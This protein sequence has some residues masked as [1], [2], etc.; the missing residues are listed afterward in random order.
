[1]GLRSLVWLENQMVLL[2]QNQTCSLVW[3]V[4]SLVSLLALLSCALMLYP[5]VL[6]GGDSM[7]HVLVL[8][9]FREHL[10]QADLNIWHPQLECGAPGWIYYQPL[11]HF[12]T[13]LISIF[14]PFEMVSVYKIIVA[15][16]ISLLPWILFFSLRWMGTSV[17][18]ALIG[19]ILYLGLNT[20]VPFGIQPATFYKKGLFTMI[21]GVSFA[22]P[23]FAALFRLFNPIAGKTSSVFTAGTLLGFTFVA[24]PVLGLMC[25]FFGLISFCIYLFNALPEEKIVKSPVWPAWFSAFS[26]IS[27]VILVLMQKFFGNWKWGWLGGGMTFLAILAL[28]WLKTPS[29]RLWWQSG[30]KLISVYVF[31]NI[32]MLP[33]SAML[34][35]NSDN[36]GG[37]PMK[38]KTFLWGFPI[39]RFLFWF[40]QGN[41]LDF[42][43]VP[44]LAPIT[45]AF[46][47]FMILFYGQRHQP[48]WQMAFCFSILTAIF[49]MGFASF[50]GFVYIN[51]A[52]FGIPHF[53]YLSGLQFACLLG[54]T[55]FLGQVLTRVR[56]LLAGFILFF[57]VFLPFV[58]GARLRL[59]PEEVL[60]HGYYMK[61]HPED[62]QKAPYFDSLRQYFTQQPVRGRVHNLFASDRVLAYFPSIYTKHPVARSWGVGGQ[63]SLS[64]FYLDCP[65]YLW[66]RPEVLE[67]FAMEYILAGFKPEWVG[68]GFKA[69]RF[70][71]THWKPVD[72]GKG[73]IT[74]EKLQES[75]IALYQY[76]GEVNLFSV[77]DIGA[78]FI[79]KS[80]AARPLLWRWM[81]SEW[82]KQKAYVLLVREPEQIPENLRTLPQIQA[83]YKHW[84]EIFSTDYLFKQAPKN[85]NWNFDWP[86][87]LEKTVS[88][89]VT[90]TEVG[91]NIFRAEVQLTQPS[92]VLF[93]MSHHP[94]WKAQFKDATTPIYQASPSFMAVYL[95]AGEGE[96]V[97]R[98][99]YPFWAKISW[100]L[101]FIFM[102]GCFIR[103]LLFLFRRR[104]TVA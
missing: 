104:P 57:L 89:K 78:V 7:T 28:L 45:W 19:A 37:F 93:K 30:K 35:L 88:G 96:L 101:F 103:W 46:L 34:F 31:A 43:T 59:D 27:C 84:E 97:F 6:Y 14:L 24:H 26:G 48:L 29:F 50:G 90:A 58:G 62:H 71:G 49:T 102:F 85:A 10:K 42:N 70:F 65:T 75:D 47:G 38:P 54:A 74:A 33:F 16:M 11:G 32:V 22:F 81:E 98:Y 17:I 66:F 18:S 15:F 1:M 40:L 44:P 100:G 82:L 2:R 39:E 3:W 41:V 91:T 64:T 79:G 9:M 63:D 12:I 23:T 60:V 5:G 8:D 25:S 86:S 53:R 56:P 36:Y 94:Y 52:S 87:N 67:L 51:P 73:T 21:W 68:K 80:K 95:P 83:E 72:F 20:F 55:L 13:A 4:L 69:D 61:Y 77:I 92:W 99:E 76:Q